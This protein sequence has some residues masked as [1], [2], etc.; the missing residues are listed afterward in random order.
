MVADTSALVAILYCEPEAEAFVER[1][2]DADVCRISVANYVEFS[3]RMR[4]PDRSSAK[5]PG[6]PAAARGRRRADPRDL[7][8]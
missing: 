1:I 4:A 2:H 3:I 7:R 8:S 5:R 6:P